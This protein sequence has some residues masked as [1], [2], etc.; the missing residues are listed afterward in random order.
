MFEIGFKSILDFII[1]SNLDGIH[2]STF[3]L[4]INIPLLITYNTGSKMR[5]AGQV[6]EGERIPSICIM[7]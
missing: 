4:F 6:S 2:A 1:N 7:K 3:M 5:L